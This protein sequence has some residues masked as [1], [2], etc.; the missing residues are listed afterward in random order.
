[1]FGA[2]EVRDPVPR[3]DL[4]PQALHA[5][6]DFAYFRRR[7]FGRISSPW[8]EQ[9]GAELVRLLES[10]DDERAVLNC[11]PGSGKST[12][13]HDVACWM[14]C[15]NRA[16]RILIVSASGRLVEQYTLRIRRSLERRFVLRAE[17]ELLRKGLAVDAEATLVDD[18]GRFRPDTES[19]WRR[20]EFVVEQL[21]GISVENKEPTVSGYGFDADYIG[22]R[23]DAALCDDVM[24][25]A[26]SRE[27]KDRDNL[28]EKWEGVTEHR[29][30]PAG[31]LLLCG[32]RLSSTDL[33][34]HC[35]AQSAG[36]D[37]DETDDETPEDD[38]PRRVYRHIVYS[39]YY[40]ELDTGPESRRP[41]APPWPLG[42]LLDPRRIPW[43]KLSALRQN[44]PDT[45]ATVYQQQDGHVSDVLV[46]EAWAFGATSAEGEMFPG[47]IDKG[48]RLGEIPPNLADPVLSVASVDPSGEK[49]WAFVWQLYQPEIDFRHVV[50]LARSR[51]S[52][53]EVITFN[54]V[55]RQCEGLMPEWQDRSMAMG[56]PITHWIVEI[57][58]AQRFL[59]AHDYV[60][61]W[62]AENQVTII[63]HTTHRYNKD[64]AEYGIQSIIP[65]IWRHG[66]IRLPDRAAC[67][68]VEAFIQEHLSWR[69]GKRSG[70]DF[71]MAGWFPELHWPVIRPSK[72]LPRLHVPEWL[73]REAI[74]A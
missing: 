51:M 41:S 38:G 61:R 52:A 23:A 25:S 13:I 55:T 42:P 35:L 17:P 73:E 71:V 45:F 64:H 1:M 57:N 28:I 74:P 34:A 47:C 59:L 44:R 24:T 54:P 10:P 21:G 72:P 5:L 20:E 29:V 50:D 15:R 30:E 37:D 58:A 12:L 63:Q 49:S 2:D 43:R 9:A 19:L 18:F 32:Q 7:Y 16:V 56:R 33:S 53:G 27:G 67:W 68:Q 70:T 31:L 66:R 62:M 60:R 22:H 48:R 40:P 11:P 65:P 14:I 26:N 4:C 46:R 39:A 36:D 8:Q 69:E 3:E 6:D